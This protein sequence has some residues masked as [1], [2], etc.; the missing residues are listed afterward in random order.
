MKNIDAVA[1]P[2]EKVTLFMKSI[3]RQ[4][5]DDDVKQLFADIGGV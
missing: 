2:Q 1:G 3:N 5:T 4:A